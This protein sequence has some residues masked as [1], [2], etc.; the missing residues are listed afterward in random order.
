M[1]V[2][3][4]LGV[5]RRPYFG[6]WIDGSR[7]DQAQ[8]AYQIQVMTMRDVLMWGQQQSCR[9]QPKSY[10]LCRSTTTLRD[11]LPLAGAYV[12]R[13]RIRWRRGDSAEFTTGL[14]HND[15]WHGAQWIKRD[16][17]DPDD[18]TYLRK[19]FLLQG[20]DVQQALLCVA[21]VH[22]YEVILNGVQIGDHP[23]TTTP[24]SILQCL[25][26]N[27]PSAIKR[28]NE[29]MVLT[30]WFGGGQGRPARRT[31]ASTQSDYHPCRW[32]HGYGRHR[33]KLAV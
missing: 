10:R 23:A 24:I 27:R 1:T 3:R 29:L 26:Y 15:D 31:R 18:Y 8:T 4:L 5:G 16:N 32:P 19:S 33:R 12:D 7:A 20:G 11:A 14:L 17:D 2:M 25:R 30:H 28:R 13:G 22:Q 6:W 21:A 9:R